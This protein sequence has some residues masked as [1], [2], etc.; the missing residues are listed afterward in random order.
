MRDQ[1]QPGSRQRSEI[2]QGNKAV[3][4]QCS[5]LRARAVKNVGYIH[6]KGAVSIVRFRAADA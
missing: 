6:P 1:D 5:S 4:Q 3:L 2:V